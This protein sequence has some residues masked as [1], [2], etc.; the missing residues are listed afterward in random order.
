MIDH[1]DLVGEVER[2]ARGDGRNPGG[3]TVQ[4]VDEVH[5][6]DQDHRG[7]DR[8]WHGRLRSET[9]GRVTVRI[10]RE[11]PLD[12]QQY[13]YP[14]G[15]DLTRKLRHGIQRPPVVHDTEQAD[16]RTGDEYRMR[17]GPVLGDRGQE[18]QLV[19]DKQPGGKPGE[20]GQTAKPWSR[21]GMDVAV[22]DARDRADPDRE[23]PRHRRAQE[24]DRRR[25]RE[26]EQILPQSS[27]AIF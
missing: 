8:Q 6:V 25:H 21:H 18:R 12:A 15:R 11:G 23:T 27:N 26:N 2:G 10:H 3:K 19:S 13:H 24:R 22:A 5:G 20:H 16:Q 7:E 1:G 9:E 17:F 4:P 14:G